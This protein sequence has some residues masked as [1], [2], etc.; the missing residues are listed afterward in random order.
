MAR[1]RYPFPVKDDLVP[2]SDGGGIVVELG[3]DVKT[4]QLG[5]HVIASFD[6]NNLDG[7]APGLKRESLGGN[8]DGVRYQ[9][10][11]LPAQVLTKVPEECGISFVQM[12]SLMASGVTA[13]NALFGVLPL[14]AGQ[15]VLF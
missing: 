1:T 6:S 10:I 4:L 14:K 15:T 2:C 5:D 9:Y 12:A 13:W 3:A 7:L 8:V 11:A